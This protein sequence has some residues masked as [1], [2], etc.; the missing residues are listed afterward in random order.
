MARILIAD[1]DASVRAAIRKT[2]TAAGHTVDEAGTG[3]VALEL[4]QRQPADLVLIDLYMPGMDGLET[5]IRIKALQPDARILAISG[6]GY[7]DKHD[8]LAMAINAGAYKTL[9]KPFE[10]EELRAAVSTA[11]AGGPA[12]SEPPRWPATS[13]ATVLLVDDD[14]RTRDILQTRLRLTGYTVMEAADAEHALERFRAQP[15]NVVVTDLVLPGKSGDDLIAA[16]RAEAPT[17]AIVA[18]SGDPDRLDALNRAF[19][20]Y[21]GFQT[22]DKPFTTEQLLDALEAVL[23]ASRR[24]EPSASWLERLL[25]RLTRIL[26]G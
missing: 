5:M 6:G 24:P 2:L 3:L 4:F 10:L 13:K 11:L 22:L 14:A 26:R 9:A 23:A 21:P 19:G 17:A 1:D 8:V 15:P 16:L 25:G 20:G 12:R 18:I 7:R